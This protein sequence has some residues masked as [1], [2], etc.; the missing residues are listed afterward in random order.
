MTEHGGADDIDFDP[1]ATAF[2]DHYASAR[3][4]IRLHL[5]HEQVNAHLPHAT[6]GRSLRILDIGGG[7]GQMALLL[8]ADDHDVTILD[9]SP[10]MLDLARDH[11]AEA[12]VG[13]RVHML[14]GGFEEAARLAAEDGSFDAVL[15]HAVAPYVSDVDA[16]L[17]AVVSAAMVGGIVSFVVKNRDALAMRPAFE[18]RWEDA[19]LAFDA[20]GD[21]GGLGVRNKA[22]GREEIEQA[23]LE[24]GADVDAWYGV[25]VFS[26]AIGHADL[27][28]IDT[29]LPVER[30][31]AARDPYRA[32]ARL[33]H[34]VATRR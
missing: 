20:D 32:V 21:A 15:C 34:L 6:D 8:A 4:R 22:H 5:L 29:I 27:V 11:V 17:D 10:A 26:D 23:L 25:R 2:D 13:D 18:R 1:Y 7:A 31:A 12:E 19:L 9:P 33:L 3:G 28:D 30:E 24:R 16:L 14:L